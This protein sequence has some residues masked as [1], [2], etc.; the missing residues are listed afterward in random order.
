MASVVW[1][2]SLKSCVG[3]ASST[4]VGFPNRILPLAHVSFVVTVSIFIIYVFKLIQVFGGR[5][6][7]LREKERRNL[8]QRKFR[9]AM[10]RPFAGAA[11]N[12][13]KPHDYLPANFRFHSR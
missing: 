2:K 13:V 10:C 11:E 3:Y 4:V 1:K 6:W 12:R 7:K 9:R 5:G 8:E